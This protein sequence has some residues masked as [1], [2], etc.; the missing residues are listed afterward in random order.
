MKR[1]VRVGL[2]CWAGCFGGLGGAALAQPE[3]DGPPGPPPANVALDEVRME[4]VE[5]KREVTGELRAVK[6]SAV[7]CEEPGQVVEML[8]DTGDQ[9]GEGQVIA[10]LDSELRTIDVA[11]LQAEV[12]SAQA[13]IDERTAQVAKAQ[14][15][16]DRLSDL[17]S[18]S[19][20][21]QNEVD[22][23]K[24]TLA[25]EQ[26]RLSQARAGLASARA[27]LQAAERRLSDMIVKAPFAGSVVLKRTEAGQW[28]DEGEAVVEMVALGA[29]D[30]YLDVPER[31]V[32]ALMSE[33]AK[34][35]LRVPAIGDTIE[36]PVSAVMAEGDRLAR[37]FQVRVR[38]ENEG[39]ASAGKGRLRPGMSVVGLVPTGEPIDAL[40]IH[41]DA[42]LRNDAGS[43]VYFNG[44][45]VAAVA[46]IE[47]L[48]ASGGDRVAVRSPVLGAGME[49]ITQGNE[50]VFPGQPL[51][52]NGQMVG[53]AAGQGGAP[54]APGEQQDKSLIEKKAEKS[55]KGSAK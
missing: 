4:R 14:R 31:F 5:L 32:G 28:V 29:V 25:A 30:A 17:M 12:G 26:A 8:V 37:T 10:R 50:R 36:A 48:F 46:P 41:K 6:R 55:S 38:V 52:V 2:V 3:G 22:D 35:L 44:G 15:D 13:T 43:F 7:A 27:E 19:G 39:E 34:V 11:R 42:V 9:V 45:G 47:M 18:R 40:T 54:G 33:G 16:L 51:M 24:T 1:F 49:V 53:A 21:S 23:A 20:A